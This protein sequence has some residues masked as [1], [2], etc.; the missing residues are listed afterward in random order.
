MSVSIFSGLWD[1]RSLWT[2]LPVSARVYLFVLLCLAV[3][4]VTKMLR[5]ALDPRKKADTRLEKRGPEIA[6]F[7]INQ[8]FQLTLLIFGVILSDLLFS[9]ARALEWHLIA[10]PDV[11]PAFDAPAAFAVIVLLTHCVLFCLMWFTRERIRAI[12]PSL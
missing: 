7:R 8:C 6:L 9:S 3:Y 4:A 2:I 10:D 1:F 11:V 5:I 12:W